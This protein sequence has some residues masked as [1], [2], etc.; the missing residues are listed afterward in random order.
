MVATKTI[1]LPAAPSLGI[2]IGTGPAKKPWIREISPSSEL[3]GALSVGDIIMDLE[4]DGVKYS[5]LP[6]TDLVRMLDSTQENPFRSL[7]VVE[8]K[9][10]RDMMRYPTQRT[11]ASQK[12]IEGIEYDYGYHSQQVNNT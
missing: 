3:D 9:M 1:T 11:Q 4:V 2:G 5:N 10:F 12:A 8:T 6:T 7:T